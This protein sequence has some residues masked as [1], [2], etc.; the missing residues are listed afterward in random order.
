MLLHDIPEGLAMAI[1]MKINKAGP[2]KI[3]LYTLLIGVPTGLGAFIGAYLGSISPLIIALCLAFAG[4][5]MLY[6]IC[7]E[8]IPSA[9]ELHKG[10]A[11]SIGVVLG[12]IIGVVL[13]IK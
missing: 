2:L 5:T 1:P 9:K 13:Y 10:R 3:V 8:M 11:S 12:F 7:D 4:G 6:I